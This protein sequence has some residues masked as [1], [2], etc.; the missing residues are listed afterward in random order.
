MRAHEGGDNALALGVVQHAQS[1]I[2]GASQV[3]KAP[4]AQAPAQARTVV[5]GAQFVGGAYVAGYGANGDHAPL[6]GAREAARPGGVRADHGQQVRVQSHESVVFAV[7]APNGHGSVARRARLSAGCARD[8]R[9]QDEGEEAR[10]EVDA[11]AL[12]ATPR[13]ARRR[14]VTVLLEKSRGRAAAGGSGGAA[15][16]VGQAGQQHAFVGEQAQLVLG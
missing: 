8:E 3:V 1:A 10:E 12:H 9:A 15:L 2:R 6:R 5:V 11:G 4:D 14:A 16:P 7:G 13:R